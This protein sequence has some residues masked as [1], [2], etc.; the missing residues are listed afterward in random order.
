MAR[1]E[2]GVRLVVAPAGVDRTDERD[3]VEHRH[4]L[5]K[6]LA[7]AD[8]RQLRLDGAEGAADLDRPVG[9]RIPGIDLARTAGHPE[10]DHALR[11]GT[12]AGIRTSL[13]HP[14]ELRNGKPGHA[15]EP[16]F[17]HVAPVGDD[18][19]LA[20]EG[21]EVGEGVAV[22]RAGRSSAVSHRVSHFL[23]HAGRTVTAP[24]G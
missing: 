20:V 7:E 9:L 8:A 23:T 3:P 1:L 10:E 17:E 15:G 2:D 16:R 21:M 11:R 12:D 19:P 6:V 5:G 4:L 18:E 13:T 14:Q 24:R 22:A